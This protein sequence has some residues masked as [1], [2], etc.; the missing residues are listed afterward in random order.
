MKKKVLFAIPSLKSGGAEKSLISVLSLFDYDKYEVDLILFRREGLF[1]ERLPEKIN[2]IYDTSD[3]EIFDGDGKKAIAYFLKKLNLSAAYDRVKYLKAFEEP[4]EI[5]SEVMAWHYL[6]KRL[7]KLRKHYDCAIGYLE[8]NTNDYIAD[9]VDAERKICFVHN[10]IGKLPFSERLYKNAF[11]ACNEIVTVSEACL[12][13][14]QTEFSDYIDK[15]HIIENITCR[16]LILNDLSEEKVYSRENNETVILTVGRCSEQKN[17]ELAVDTCK[18]LKERNRNIK[19]YHIGKGMLEEQVKRY[20][21]ETGMENDFIMLGERANPYPYMEQCDIYVQTSRFEGKSIAIDEVK[22]LHKPIVVTNFPS[23][24]DQIEDGVNG[25]ICEMNKLDMADKID[26][27]IKD[28]GK[29]CILSKNL[30]E[31]KTGNEEELLKLY[32][33]IDG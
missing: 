11:E 28:S 20:V 33:L 15:M 10:D 14:L 24:Y 18:E 16:N 12:S 1:L 23:A 21:A 27:L 29:R 5:T 19:W 26:I 25:I 13:S 3:F 32:K 7:P 6:K 30:S 31:E 2:H 22:C 9:C 4:D 8:G 17:I